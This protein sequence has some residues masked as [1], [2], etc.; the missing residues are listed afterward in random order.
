MSAE[1]SIQKFLVICLGQLVSLV[2]SGMTSFALGI[3]VYQHTGSITRFALISVAAMLPGIVISP[4]AGAVVDR[5]NRR[6]TMLW[7][8]IGA[9][10]CTLFLAILFFTGRLTIWEIYLLVSL[11][12]LA[13]AFRMP[14]YMA[15]LS[16]LVPKDHIGRASGLMQLGPGA[17]QVLS[18]VLA[19]ALL[20]KIN[21]QG[22]I[23]IDF[24]TFVFA[25]GTLSLI[26]V[27]TLPPKGP[28][29]SILKE[30]SDGWTYIAGRPG[31]IGLLIFAASTNITYGFW[32]A[33]STPMILSFTNT[34]VLGTIMSI[35]ALGF[36]SGSL[37]MSAWGGPQ[38]RVHG[39]LGFAVLYGVGLILGGVKA[40]V[41]LITIAFFVMMFQVP[42]MN[43]C[44]QAIWQTKVPLEMQGRV[45]STRIMVALS[46]GPL[47]LFLAGPL[48]DKVF[49]PM[50]A[51]HGL[52]W[53]TGLTNITGAGPGRGAAFLLILSGILALAIALGCYFNRHLRNVEDELPDSIPAREAVMGG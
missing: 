47:A 13:G 37:V 44:S 46:C 41:P 42:M 16:Q 9:G 11:S 14:A 8:D 27:P 30:A 24:T 28:K 12:S 3:W 29:R 2:G 7:S 5:F 36:L 39:L 17:A 40:S 10:F 35:G 51:T 43:G 20:G 45:F 34:G 38:R 50:F 18:P 21:F 1:R 48:A 4:I 26:P 6:A 52:A 49:E 32:Q 53:S 23:A 22:I 19:A 25:I 31:L 33:V 15:L